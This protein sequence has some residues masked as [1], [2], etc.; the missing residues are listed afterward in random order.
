[1][2]TSNLVLYY[3]TA[4]EHTDWSINSIHVSNW[5]QLKLKYFSIWLADQYTNFYDSS[6][7]E[8]EVQRNAFQ[9]HFIIMKIL[10]ESPLLYCC[11]I[12]HKFIYSFVFFLSEF[13]ITYIDSIWNHQKIVGIASN[14]L[15]FQKWSKITHW[16]R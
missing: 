13:F 14:Q 1:M 9:W 12:E 11:C 16:M 3:K 4:A 5:N 8:Y 7:F 6:W 10:F 2:F 15:F